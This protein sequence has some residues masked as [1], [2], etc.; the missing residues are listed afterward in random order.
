MKNSLHKFI[1]LQAIQASAVILFIFLSKSETEQAAILW[2]SK[3]RIA[4]LIAAFGIFALSLWALKDSGTPNSFVRKVFHKIEVSAVQNKQLIPIIMG[5]AAFSGGLV[6][7]AAKI[8]STPL[9]YS[10]YSTWAPDSFP[11][12]FAATKNLAP[13]LA[14]LIAFPVE[15]AG[16]LA[17]SNKNCFRERAYWNWTAISSM[18][19]VLVII[20]ANFVYWVILLL[21]LKW[22]VSIPAWYWEFII[23]PWSINDI[24]YVLVAGISI[25]IAALLALKFKK[26]ALALVVIFITGW[27]MQ[28]G[29]GFL[30]GEGIE[31]FK[32]RYFGTY[33]AAYPKLAS[34]NNNSLFENIYFYDN[35]FTDLFTRTKPPG[36]MSI[37][38]ALERIINGNPTTSGLTDELRY[39]R[40]SNAIV[41]I[42]PILGMAI[43]FLLYAF[44]QK[45]LIFFADWQYLLPPTLLIFTPN[46]ILFSLFADQVIY[47]ALFLSGTWLIYIGFSRQSYF[48]AFGLGILL[49]IFAFFAFTM[50]PLFIVAGVFL[51]MLWWQAPD[52]HSLIDQFKKGVV[53]LLGAVAAYFLFRGLLNYD[54][55]PR[56]S[57]TTTI[58]HNMD[59]YLRVGQEIPLEKEPLT[60]RLSQI[61]NAMWVN[62]L[63]FATTVGIGIYILFLIY[64]IRL[65]IRT[66]KR[67]FESDDIY[68][69]SLFFSF[70]ILNLSG[71]TQGEVARLWLF[72]VPMV[73]ILASKEI[74]TRFKNPALITAGLIFIQMITILLTFHYQDLIMSIS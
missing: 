30:E 56:F 74:I 4:L 10:V 70:L 28:I 13:F 22:L 57:E 46:F 27:M 47:P 54:F 61:F 41:L 37:Y 24:F 66:I 33:H 21:Q 43:V 49:Y 50:L 55:I 42:F 3:S 40:L 15:L 1:T 7:I 12:I 25:G 19:I 48:A 20:V 63:E 65:I 2:F 51:F 8:L 11:T 59:F 45:Y 73:V 62:N 5:L 39:D 34:V 29:I 69:A 36:L 52:R 14:L 9:D 6:T 16:F 58:N 38:T 68:L 71:S 17:V 72:W 26:I 64:G 32:N 53:F 67:R 60:T 35:T 44:S 23:K 18:I 31:S